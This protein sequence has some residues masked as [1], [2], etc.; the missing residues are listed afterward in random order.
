MHVYWS[1]RVSKTEFS[2]FVIFQ[3]KTKISPKTLFQIFPCKNPSKIMINTSRMQNIIQMY[4]CLLKLSRKQ[5]TILKIGII[6]VRNWR[7][8]ELLKYILTIQQTTNE[9]TTNNYKLDRP[10]MNIWDTWQTLKYL[11]INENRKYVCGLKYIILYFLIVIL[12]GFVN[13][14][15]K[16]K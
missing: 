11:N 5:D 12:F 8:C 2:K 4:P 1:Y 10:Y 13:I 3:P 9:L 7:V 16:K 6:Y 14:K 15:N